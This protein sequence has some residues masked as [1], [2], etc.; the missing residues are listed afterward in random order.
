MKRP[1]RQPCTCL[2][3]RLT[4]GQAVRAGWDLPAR[5]RAKARD[6]A[7]QASQ[8]VLPLDAPDQSD[9]TTPRP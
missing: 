6:A 2:P 4:F 9:E 3:C 5:K 7:A 1:H 8:L